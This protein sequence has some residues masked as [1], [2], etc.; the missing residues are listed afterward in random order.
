MR[1]VRKGPVGLDRGSGDSRQILHQAHG[2][3]AVIEWVLVGGEEDIATFK[4]ELDAHCHVVCG[5]SGVAS[6]R[7]KGGL[8]GTGRDRW[9]L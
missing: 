2:L 6:V 8:R 4:E 3:L 5:C 1:G 7:G 9:G